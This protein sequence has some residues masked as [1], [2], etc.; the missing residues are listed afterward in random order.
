MLLDLLTIVLLMFLQ[1]FSLEK[2]MCNIRAVVFQK[3]FQ[4]RL[5]SLQY[6]VRFFG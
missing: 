4:E 3:L 5:S 1:N 2:L 6:P